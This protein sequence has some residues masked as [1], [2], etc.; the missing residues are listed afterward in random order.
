LGN[1]G[2]A[3][4]ARDEA[5]IL[6]EKEGGLSAYALLEDGRPVL[7]HLDMGPRESYDAWFSVLLVPAATFFHVPVIG[8]FPLMLLKRG[9]KRAPR[10][11]ETER[12]VW[13][14]IATRTLR[15]YARCRC[16]SRRGGPSRCKTVSVRRIRRI[17]FKANRASFHGKRHPS[18]M[19]AAE[20]SS[21]LT[22][23]ATNLRVSAST[24]NQALSAVLFW[25]RNVLHLEIGLIDR[26]PR[27]RMPVRVP[28]VL[29]RDE[30]ARIMTHLDGVTWIMVAILY[31][32]GLRLQECLELRV[33]DIDLERRQIV[34]R[35]GKGQKDRPTVL[36]H[37]VI[38]PLTRHLESVKRQREND[39]ARGF[40]ALDRKYPN[41]PTE[42][43]WQFVFPASRVCTDPK[44]G[45]PTRFHVHESAVQKAVAHAAR[46][47]G[48]TK[49]VGPHTFRHSFATHLLEDGYDIRTVQELL[50]HADVSTTM[51]YTHVLNRGP[52]GM[53]SPVDRL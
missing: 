14:L 31:G 10:W 51:V 22:W 23:L 5:S 7:P 36:P 6:N 46:Q 27:A 17:L 9:A 41:A 3:S 11:S 29:S 15:R 38:A 48:I 34:I 19:G 45:P 26:V 43:A 50:A 4:A 28:V 47:V 2:I 49:R 20:I 39:L 30:V 25:Y 53:R 40:G 1:D 18:E 8:C 33:K 12:R 32:A 24:Q 16:M 42:W 52:F 35:R 21:F 37:A 44:W 13:R